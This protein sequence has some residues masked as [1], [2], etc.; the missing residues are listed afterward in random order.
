[1]K[2]FFTRYF[3]LNKRL[4]KKPLFIIILCIVPILVFALNA[5]TVHNDGIIDIAV[6]LEDPL[7]ETAQNIASRLTDDESMLNITM[8][9]SVTD[10]VDSVRYG[11]SDC[12]WILKE[13]MKN[14][15]TDYVNG[16]GSG[17][18]VSIIERENT[19]ALNIAREK[20]AAA[21]SDDLCSILMSEAYRQKIGD[22]IDEAE[23]KEYYNE[24][25]NSG[26]I[27]EYKRTT[28]E[29]VDYSDTS[30]LMLPIRGILALSVLLCGFAMTLFFIGDEKRLV[31][32]RMSRRSRPFFEI[33][34]HLI[35]I[36]D[37]ALIVFLSILLSG[38]ATSLWREIL[39]LILYSINCA[40]FVIA[41]RKL[42][43]KSERIAVM[44][45]FV[46]VIM[47]IVNPVFINLPFV[48]PVRVITPLY[49]Y[50]Q[51]AYDSMFL[52]YALIYM[53]V[54]TLI[55]ILLSRFIEKTL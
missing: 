25:F 19:V 17:K 32:C 13:D 15:L 49:Y 16:H 42:L 21:I 43:R 20:L 29:T 6:A 28:G 10:A 22:N 37:I 4:F 5:S 3:L 54:L 39:S 12:A 36:F 14:T 33:G 40:L 52:L 31:F 2:K 18:C 24:A 46:L 55:N 1:M 47:I 51:S 35:G 45:P 23:L 11:E 27:I 30:Y 34:Y 50:L 7:D 26:D 41:I 44:I 9:D 48:Y 38:L 53:C 8:Y